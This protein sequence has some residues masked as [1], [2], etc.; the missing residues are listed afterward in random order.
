MSEKSKTVTDTVSK[1]LP[2]NTVLS[3]VT[4]KPVKLPQHPV[5]GA[6]RS[7]SEFEKLNRIGEG[8]Y[9]VVYRA[10]D[11]KSGEIVALKNPSDHVYTILLL[12]QRRVQQSL[13]VQAM[14]LNKQ[15]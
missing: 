6:C 8:T 1:E 11:L 5:L 3:P 12:V 4:L 13:I 7:V 10:R 2:S 14:F 15:E 9:G